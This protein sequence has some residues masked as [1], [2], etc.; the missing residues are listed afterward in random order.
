MG[1]G[2]VRN[3]QIG[4]AASDISSPAGERKPHEYHMLE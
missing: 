4:L 1:G 3:G 2:R